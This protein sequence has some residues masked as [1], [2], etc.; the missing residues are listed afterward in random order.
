MA[1]LG[2]ARPGL[3][4]HGEA[5]QAG[6]AWNFSHLTNE[7]KMSDSYTAKWRNGFRGW[8]A[9]SAELAH[10]ELEKLRKVKGGE[11]LPAEV[12][13]AA[14]AKKSKLHGLF[15][16][17][18]SIAAGKHREAQARSILRSIVIERPEI[19]DAES[20]VYEVKRSVSQPSTKAYTT[21]EEVMQDPEAKA[22]LLQRALGE[23]LAIRRR[24]HGLQELAIVFREVETLLETMKV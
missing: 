10:K 13:S 18:D 1:W 19:G 21:L 17:D 23:L 9:V 24:Y 5:G 16:W 20:R 6:Q 2:E 4:G 11:L 7:E 14:I 3:A 22:E 8:K 15:E 12:V